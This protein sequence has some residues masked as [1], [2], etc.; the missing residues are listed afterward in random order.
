[1]DVPLN[2]PTEEPLDETPEDV[3]ILYS[4]ANLPGARYRDFS[5]SRREYR[6]QVRHRAA[7]ELRQVELEAQAQ[8]ETA[9]TE[10]ERLAREAERIARVSEGLDRPL[11]LERALREAEEA[12]RRAAVERVEAAR[13]AEA[14]AIAEAAANREEREIVEARASAERQT[15]RWKDSERRDLLP[16]FQPSSG[17]DPYEVAQGA[18]VDGNLS[19]PNEALA[20]TQ[21]ERYRSELLRQEFH[22]P[23]P[24]PVFRVDP[25]SHWPPEPSAPAWLFGGNPSVATAP[26]ANLAAALKKSRELVASRW[27]ALNGAHDL[28]AEPVPEPPQQENTR[29]PCLAVFSLAGGVGKTTM[30]ATLGRVL[31]SLGEEVMLADTTS[32]GLLPYYFGA[33]ELKHGVMRTFSPPSGS[34][35]APIHLVGYDFDQCLADKTSQRALA[36]EIAKSA[37]G[38][39]RL[40]LDCNAGSGWLMRSLTRMKPTVLVPV[41]PDMN[42]VIGLQAVERYLQGAVDGE[43]QPVQPYYLLNQ[44]DP[45][46]PLH[47]DVREMLRRTLGDRLLPC[48]IHRS[49]A[50]GEALAEGMTVVDYQPEAAIAEDFLKLAKWLQGVSA[51]AN[52][53]LPTMLRGER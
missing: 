20:Y 13:R 38:V 50:V 28:L 19:T 7:E 31:S 17:S 16:G 23:D 22:H 25:P 26:S 45:S 35:D 42:A 14:A 44:F 49:H 10:S 18:T 52:R 37:A 48:V 15:A 12:A 3:A 34:T 40:L 6:A 27:Q 1:M 4:W 33:T 36:E 39:Q 32:H 2:D 47:L 29:I 41:A 9:A 46:L 53:E 30:V 21:P 5:A 11:E 24:R 51:A 8:A 43:D